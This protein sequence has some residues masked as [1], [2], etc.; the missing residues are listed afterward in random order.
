MGEKRGM[1]EAYYTAV[2]SGNAEYG[3]LT[4]D[5]MIAHGI[6]GKRRPLGYALN[7]L[8]VY[9]SFDTLKTAIR[10]LAE[11]LIKDRICH[12]GNAVLIAKEAL[13]H[14]ATENC[15]DCTGSGVVSFDQAV[16]STCRGSG[17]RGFPTNRAIAQAYHV[18]RG[19]LSEIEDEMRGL[20]HG[21]RRSAPTRLKQVIP[22]SSNIPVT[23]AVTMDTNRLYNGEK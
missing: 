15:S 14:W 18:I 16:C 3:T 6:A 22:G 20:M 4:C 10:L 13:R 5:L 11:R 8:R 1:L 19:A 12:D 17:K 9:P 23:G 2:Q 21:W 7:H